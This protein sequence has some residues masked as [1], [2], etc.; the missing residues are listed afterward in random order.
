MKNKTLDQTADPWGA[1]SAKQKKQIKAGAKEII[2][3]KEDFL[4]YDRFKFG[5]ADIL[6]D[7]NHSYA[8]GRLARAVLDEYSKLLAAAHYDPYVHKDGEPGIQAWTNLDEV[9]QWILDDYFST[10]RADTCPCIS[11]NGKLMR[12]M[13]P[14]DLNS[15][16]EWKFLGGA[17]PLWD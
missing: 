4:Q 10:P 13:Y 9:P 17:K 12:A 14:W 16:F 15:H 5:S 3:S 6:Y 11:R 7:L 2:T 1:L 8:I